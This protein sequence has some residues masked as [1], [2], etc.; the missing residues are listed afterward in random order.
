MGR[1][2]AELLLAQGPVKAALDVIGNPIVALF[3]GHRGHHHRS[4]DRCSADPEQHSGKPRTA[5]PCDGLG[6]ADPFPCERCWFLAGEGILWLKRGRDFQILDHDG[7]IA[8][9]PWFGG[10][11]FGEFDYLDG[12]LAAVGQLI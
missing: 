4:R 5:G 8:V 12:L 10:R 6:F 3:I 1:S 9:D 7:N 11:S 2:V